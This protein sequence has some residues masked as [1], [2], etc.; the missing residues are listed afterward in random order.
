VAEVIGGWQAEL[1]WVVA[2]IPRL[3]TH[4]EVVC[5]LRSS[6]QT[7]YLVDATSNITTTLNRHC[8]LHIFARIFSVMHSYLDCDVSRKDGAVC[9]ILLPA[10]GL[11]SLSRAMYFCSMHSILHLMF[12]GRAWLLRCWN[13]HCQLPS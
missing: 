10:F 1:A 13:V 9:V 7:E 5:Q 12:G 6:E 4:P 11:L 2:Y 8:L 3:F